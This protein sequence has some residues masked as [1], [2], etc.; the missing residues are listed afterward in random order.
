MRAV[1]FLSFFGRIVSE[2]GLVRILP[3]FPAPPGPPTA[4]CGIELTVSVSTVIFLAEPSPEGFPLPAPVNDFVAGPLG[5][6]VVCGAADVDLILISPFPPLSLPLSLAVVV[7][8]GALTVVVEA[9]S[10]EFSCSVV[11]FNVS[12]FSKTRSNSNP[13]VFGWLISCTVSSVE[14]APLTPLAGVLIPGI[15]NESS[16][17]VSVV[18][19]FPSC[20]SAEVVDRW[21]L[22][23]GVS[24]SVFRGERIEDLLTG[25]GDR[26]LGDIGQRGDSRTSELTEGF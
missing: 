20:D 10:V 25:G 5:R 24:W 21:T 2:L 6:A 1:F 3:L 15:D 22:I 14:L 19:C 8:F 11:N 7:G 16:V 13:G 18:P 23:E 12:T 9:L 26:S 17:S 4:T